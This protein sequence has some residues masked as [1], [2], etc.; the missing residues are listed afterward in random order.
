MGSDA[1]SYRRY[2]EGDDNGLF[3]IMSRYNEGLTLFINGIVG[4]ICAAEEIMQETFIVIAVKKPRFGGRS[5]F[6]T[7]LFSIARNKAVDSLRRKPK[8]QIPMDAC[9]RL[10]D[11]TDIERSFLRDEQKIELHRAL[12]ELSPEYRQVIELMYFEG[13]DNSQTAKIMRRT[14]RQVRNLLYRA[15]LALKKQL[16][17]GG[18]VYE[19]L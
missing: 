5:D 19:E 8:D 4:D 14:K 2:L 13:F 7:W 9:F 16:E 15:K 17:K 1:D 10:S 6:K 12:T 11:E 18:F 3:E